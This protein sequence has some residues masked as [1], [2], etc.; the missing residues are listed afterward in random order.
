VTK[1]YF[2]RLILPVASAGSYLVDLLLSI[3]VLLILM[4]G[5][6]IFPGWR[7]AVLPVLVVFT[8]ASATGVGIWLT[9]LNARYRDVRYIVPFLTQIWLLASPIAY[10]SGRVPAGTY[11]I[12]YNLNPMVAIVEG[13]RWSLLGIPWT[14][15]WLPGISVLVSVLILVSGAF[16]FRR[17]ERTF[18]DEL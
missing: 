6:G 2:P 12:L 11:R 7:I 16:F 4:A 5:F 18:A 9:A 14:L 13:F 15:G 17:I 3:A 10:S 1:V 8:L